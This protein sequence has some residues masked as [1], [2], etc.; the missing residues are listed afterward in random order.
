VGTQSDSAQE[1]TE[2]AT[3]KRQESARQEGRLPRSAELT[4]AAVVLTCAGGLHFLGKSLGGDLSSLLRVGLT[5]TREQALQSGEIGPQLAGALRTAMYACAP[6]FGLVVAA[7]LLAPLALGGWNF[8]P[9]AL[10]PNFGRLSPQAGLARMFSV[11]GLVELGKSLAKFALVALIAVWIL[12]RDSNA[13]LALGRE[14]LNIA[15]GHAIALSAEALLYLASGLLVIAAVDVPFQLWQHAKQLRM[16]REEIR[17]EMKDTDGSP[18]VKNRIRS[19][20]Q[21]LAKRRMMHE[22]PTADVVVVNPTHYAV[23]LRYDESRMRAPRVVAKGVDL[24]AARIR[25]LASDHKI[26]IFEAPPLARA[27][28]RGCDIGSEIPAALYVAVAQVLSYV[29]QLRDARRSGASPPPAPEVGK[30]MGPATSPDT[31]GEV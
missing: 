26:P 8:S 24:I 16:S 6:L 20:Q 30:R 1:R 21:A 13:L 25:E 5:L 17:E 12:A 29:F 28:Y 4:A 9:Q 23:A 18:E 3:P 11:R 7:A 2:S 31:R 19:V 27:L 22:V 10:V 15:I 14:P